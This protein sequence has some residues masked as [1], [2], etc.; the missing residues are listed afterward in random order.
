MTAFAPRFSCSRKGVHRLS[1]EWT[2][3]VGVV[4]AEKRYVYYDTA[5]GPLVDVCAVCEG[6]EE[7]T[8]EKAM[9]KTSLTPRNRSTNLLRFVRAGIVQTGRADFPSS[10]D[11]SKRSACRFTCSF[12]S[13][14]G[15]GVRSKRLPGRLGLWRW[16]V[17]RQQRTVCA[18][19]RSTPRHAAATDLSGTAGNLRCYCTLCHSVSTASS[20]R[21]AHTTSEETVYFIVLAHAPVPP[22]RAYR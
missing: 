6:R 16:Q 4:P 15:K 10:A 2:N 18:C 1:M 7:R 21:A 9:A 22:L 3:I 8:R 19:I 17:H 5:V 20:R 11:P 12:F 13:A 14:K